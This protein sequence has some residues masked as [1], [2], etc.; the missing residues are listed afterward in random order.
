MGYRA[1]LRFDYG[2]NDEWLIIINED[3]TEFIIKPNHF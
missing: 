1:S 3:K 2:E